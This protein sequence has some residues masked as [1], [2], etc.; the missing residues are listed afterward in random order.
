MAATTRTALK[1]FLEQLGLNVTAFQDEAPQGKVP[2][3]IVILGPISL[4]PDSLED[5][6][7]LL[8]G[9]TLPAGA[10]RPTGVAQTVTELLQ[11]DIWQQWRNPPAPD[12]DHV[13][14]QADRALLEDYTLPD[15]VIGAI[16]GCRLLAAPQVVYGCLVRGVVRLF[17][18]DSN[19]IH[20][21][22]T[23][24]VHRQMTG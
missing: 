7:T 14:G 9:G 2:P 6:G 11:V 4:V 20:H 18:R 15:K 12:L 10:T 8:I 24:A 19:R 3:Y 1:A 13:A 17:E 22:I 5:G 21:A 16:H 23:V